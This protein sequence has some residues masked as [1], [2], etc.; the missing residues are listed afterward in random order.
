MGEAELFGKKKWVEVNNFLGQLQASNF[1][2]N[3]PHPVSSS[4]F[5]LFSFSF[6]AY[7]PPPTRKREEE[8][9]RKERRRRGE[10]KAR[11][12]EVK[13]EE[14]R[15]RLLLWIW[16]YWKSFQLGWSFYEVKLD[17]PGKFYH[18]WQ[19]PRWFETCASLCRGC[20]ASEWGRLGRSWLSKRQSCCKFGS[21][22]SQLLTSTFPC[23]V[24]GPTI[25]CKV[26][27]RF[28]LK[29]S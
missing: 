29:N 26:Y 12:E 1:W 14:R 24:S 27:N 19:N 13:R 10:G 4:S 23:R 6:L 18:S 7:R 25:R 8:R 15:A 17:N 3:E 21:F 22:I 16:P 9:K 5:P 20:W 11:R 2:I 28:F